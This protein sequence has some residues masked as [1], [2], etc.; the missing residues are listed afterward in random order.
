MSYRLFAD[1]TCDLPK[2]IIEKYNI[3]IIPLSVRFGD[4]E[5]FDLTPDEFYK[6]LEASEV[7]PTTSQVSPETFV[8]AFKKE[9]DLGNKI[10]CVT[11]GSNASGTF[12]SA[13]I[14]KGMLETEDITLIDSNSLCLGTGMI[15]LKIARMLHEN[16]SLEEIMEMVNFHKNNKIEHLFCVDTLKYL[17][18]GGRIKASKAV[19]AEVLNIKPVLVVEDAI[20]VP[21]GKVRGR[22][23]IISYFIE[24]IKSN[25]DFEKTD[26]MFVGHSQDRAFADKMVEAIKNELGYNGEIIVGEIGAIIGVHAGPGVLSVFYIKK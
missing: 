10:I 9:L 8:S 25:I 15:V 1:S 12:Q 22:N 5:F 7:L 14:A 18:K 21:F 16:K 26:L 17:R 19:I 6:K 2:D 13:C 11:I 4:E 23:K 20:T 24:H 3:N